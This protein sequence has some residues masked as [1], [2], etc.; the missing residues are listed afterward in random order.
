M[1][2]PRCCPRRS[3]R[4]TEITRQNIRYHFRVCSSCNRC[5]LSCFPHFIPCVPARVPSVS[6]GF[7]QF[8]FLYFF[9][10]FIDFLIRT[11]QLLCFLFFF[12]TCLFFCVSHLRFVCV[13]TP[14]PVAEGRLSFFFHLPAS[15][16]VLRFGGLPTVLAA[17]DRTFLLLGCRAERIKLTRDAVE[18]YNS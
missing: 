18:I 4:R 1:I 5:P 8:S 9:Y 16:G 7:S 17:R 10:F 11:C 13:W 12:A 2:N 6:L 14:R 15:R 3:S